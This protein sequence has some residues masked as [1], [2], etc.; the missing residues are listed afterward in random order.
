MLLEWQMATIFQVSMA[1]GGQDSLTLAKTTRFITGLDRHLRPKL[2]PGYLED[3]PICLGKQDAWATTRTGL[4]RRTVPGRPRHFRNRGL[5]QRRTLSNTMERL[6]WV[7]R[8]LVMPGTLLSPLELLCSR[9]MRVDCS[10]SGG[11]AISID[12]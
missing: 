10:D 1:R 5:L 4:T 3:G 12:I 9:S 7:Y 2:P 6:L 11:L 8:T